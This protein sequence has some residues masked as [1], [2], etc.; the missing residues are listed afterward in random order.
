MKGEICYLEM[1]TLR[2]GLN[3]FAVKY[4]SLRKNTRSAHVRKST[5]HIAWGSENNDMNVKR[6]V[7]KE[8]AYEYSQTTCKVFY[9]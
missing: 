5:N 8:D 6:A 7:R 1:G 4:L 3:I 2:S 9:G